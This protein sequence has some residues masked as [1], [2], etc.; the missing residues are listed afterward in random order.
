MYMPVYLCLPACT[1][2]SVTNTLVQDGSNVSMHIHDYSVPQLQNKS[3][4]TEHPVS[5]FVDDA[6]KFIM[7][8][9]NDPRSWETVA[10][11]EGSCS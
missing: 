5:N 7:S 9:K 10:K 8:R 4:A 2:G 6:I 1:A 3:V 11:S